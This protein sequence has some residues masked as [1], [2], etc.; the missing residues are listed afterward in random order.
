VLRGEAA[1]FYLSAFHLNVLAENPP[2]RL[3][4][5]EIEQRVLARLD[6][7][8]QTEKEFHLLVRHCRDYDEVVPHS[9]PTYA[10]GFEPA[11]VGLGQFI[12]PDSWAGPHGTP[13]VADASPL[14]EFIC[15]VHPDQLVD[16]WLRINHVGADGVPAQELMSRLEKAWGVGRPLVLPAKEDWAAFS[17]PRHSPGRA[18]AAE[19]QTFI[20]FSPLLAWRKRENQKLPAP[21]TVSAAI[22][23]QL[24]RHPHFAPLFL[25]TTVEVPA[26]GGLG[27]GVAIVVVRPADYFS[28]PDGL[29]QFVAAFNLELARTKQRAS[30]ALKTLDAAALLPPRLEESLLRHTLDEGGRGFGSLGLTIL[31][32]ARIF[33]SPFADAG[34]ANGFIALGSM[35]LP[36]ADGKQVGCVVVKGP[37][38]RIGEYGRILHEA[39]GQPRTGMGS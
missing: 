36:A 8:M 27:R 26:V 12:R 30:A 29:A 32:D 16:V 10:V 24:A 4:R 20:D 15:R 23:W 9:G 35:T 28:R 22:L 19:V 14:F 5:A 3:S 33:G 17:G 37:R 1:R 21:M 34:H 11:P 25:G 13:A 6:A 31:K 7:F 2:A 18:D 38:G 39:L